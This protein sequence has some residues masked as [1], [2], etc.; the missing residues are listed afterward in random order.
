MTCE[1]LCQHN[2]AL[3]RAYAPAHSFRSDLGHTRPLVLCVCRDAAVPLAGACS[4]RPKADPSS[5]QGLSAAQCRALRDV[6]FIPIAN[7]TVLAAPSKVGLPVLLT[8]CLPRSRL[9]GTALLPAAALCCRGSPL[10]L[11]CGQL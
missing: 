8:S 9:H 10:Y 11:G 1:G 4:A 6:P 5:A 3:H 7:A 2:G